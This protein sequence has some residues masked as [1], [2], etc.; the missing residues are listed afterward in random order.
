MCDGKGING[1]LQLDNSLLVA[2]SYEAELLLLNRHSGSVI[3]KI[4]VKS[5]SKDYFGIRRISEDLAVLRDSQFI[6]VIDLKR[7]VCFPVF[8]TFFS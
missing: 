5:G 8:K 4:Q 3:K 1:L 7:N 6:N 2:I